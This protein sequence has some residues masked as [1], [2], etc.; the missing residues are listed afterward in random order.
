M[1]NFYTEIRGQGSN[2]VHRLG[3]SYAEG[4]VMSWN[5]GITVEAVKCEGEPIIGKRGGKTPTYYNAW[6]VYI[7]SGTTQ[8]S[9]SFHTT[10]VLL[11]TLTEKEIQNLHKLN[12]I[13]GKIS[14][15]DLYLGKHEEK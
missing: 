5:E 14:L 3:N 15:M 10:K 13:K 6:H 9:Y 4:N 8:N 7:N 12:H 11:F 1:A 2:P